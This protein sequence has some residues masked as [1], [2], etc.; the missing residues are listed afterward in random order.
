[1]GDAKRKREAEAAFQDRLAA[2]GTIMEGIDIEEA[3]GL[4]TLTLAHIAI[5]LAPNNKNEAKGKAVAYTGAV[6]TLIDEI[7]LGD[8]HRGLLGMPEVTERTDQ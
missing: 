4:M 3:M 7:W 6:Q 5:M 2:I 1:M 8:F